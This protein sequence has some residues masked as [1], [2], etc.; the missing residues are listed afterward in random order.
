LINRLLHIIFNPFVF[1]ALVSLLIYLI[2]PKN[3]YEIQLEIL[4][5]DLIDYDE[6]IL[7]LD[8][9]GDGLTEKLY[10]KGYQNVPAVE[11][12]ENDGRFYDYW[13]Y[14]GIRA[15]ETGLYYNDSDKNGHLELYTF[16]QKNDSIYLN[17]L[18]P[19]F[20]KTWEPQLLPIGKINNPQDHCDYV[21]L[22]PVFHDLNDDGKDEMI[23][24]ISSGYGLQPRNLFAVDLSQNTIKVSPLSYARPRDPISVFEALDGSKW[25]TMG[26]SATGNVDNP[27]VPFSDHSAWLMVFNENLD[28]RF[29]PVELK[30]KQKSI[31]SLFY[32]YDNR[33]VIISFLYNYRAIENRNTILLHSLGGKQ[34]R[35]IHL[36]TIPDRDVNDLTMVPVREGN[37]ERLILFSQTGDI[38]ELS[39]Q[40]KLNEIKRFKERLVI[41]SFIDMDGDQ[42]KEFLLYKTK[43]KRLTITDSEFNEFAEMDIDLKL[44]GRFYHAG[45]INNSEK[46]SIY[47]QFGNRYLEL[48]LH[49]IPWINKFF[50]PSIIY[51]MVLFIVLISRQIQKYT[52]KQ[53]KETENQLIQ[54]QLKSTLNQLDP[55]FAFNVINTISYSILEDKK[56]KANEYLVDFSRL[57]RSTLEN[58]DKISWPLSTEL[59]FV[60]DYLV[61][62]QS[63]FEDLFE[64]EITAHADRRIEIPKLL[65]HGYVDNAIKHGLRPKGKDGMIK[66]EINQQKD[67]ILISI[68]DNGIGLEA[69]MKSK[70]TQ[71]TQK[72]LKLNDELIRLYNKLY[73]KNI[74][75]E[76]GNNPDSPGT[77]VQ[78]TIPL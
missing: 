2:Y 9:D 27:K 33:D 78:I 60:E 21:I 74:Q 31:N 71:G 37:T 49:Q 32:R 43:S 19:T 47:I 59:Q 12:Y 8:L 23:F 76:I 55:H 28:F 75:L 44:E 26:S 11:I 72:G 25:I 68:T 40:L 73:K 42:E 41:I 63:R 7:H 18:E 15:C 16:S 22:N 34:I 38:Y 62:Q 66:I 61:L 45:T 65:I 4:R 13:T 48:K 69:S 57:L 35:E 39:D 20:D 14:P 67:N 54:L 3:N 52:I 56:E 17:W 6:N 50:L 10:M 58:S 1:S 64:Y 51:G 30:G 53:K 77:R 46:K 5:D 29:D 24:G 70:S 36:D